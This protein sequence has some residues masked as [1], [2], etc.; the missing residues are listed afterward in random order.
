MGALL[1]F[2]V[3]LGPLGERPPLG[4]RDLDLGGA[5]DQPDDQAQDVAAKFEHL[6]GGIDDPLAR[7]GACRD[8]GQAESE[9]D[10]CHGN[11]EEEE[12]D[13]ADQREHAP[14]ERLYHRAREDPADGV[15][16]REAQ[17]Q[18][19][20][21][22]DPEESRTQLQQ[23]VPERRLG[24]GLGVSL[25]PEDRKA[26]SKVK[27]RRRNGHGEK[28]QAHLQEHAAIAGR[29]R[30]VGQDR[31]RLGRDQPQE[32]HREPHPEDERNL[33]PPRVEGEREQVLGTGGRRA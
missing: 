4:A 25:E 20:R 33:A 30:M 9:G 18:I 31:G 22:V 27:E 11:A 21:R 7:V 1:K 8:R 26:L 16:R 24:D 3:D 29:D 13:Q 32:R 15:H 6:A 2:P 5:A 28:G 10:Q 19:S 12:L 17:G 23:A 14:Q